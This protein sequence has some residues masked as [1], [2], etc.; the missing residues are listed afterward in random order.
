MT[1]PMEFSE[2]FATPQEFEV[3]DE[4]DAVGAFLAKAALAAAGGTS[5]EVVERVEAAG[6][7]RAA[8]LDKARRVQINKLDATPTWLNSRANSSPDLLAKRS[9]GERIEV[10]K[11]T[12]N[13]R[14]EKTTYPN[15]GAVFAE[16]D[17]NGVCIR[18][19][20]EDKA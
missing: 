10:V 14:I 9:G 5:L 6:A 3:R 12:A 1:V 17:E 16:F 15:G 19:W 7:Q 8:Q 11:K 18:T 13:G 4:P 20:I 2:L